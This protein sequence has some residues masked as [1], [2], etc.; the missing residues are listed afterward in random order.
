MAHFGRSP[1]K[2]ALP[3]HHIIRLLCP[4]PSS[5]SASSRPQTHTCQMASTTRCY[6]LTI[7]LLLFLSFLGLGAAAAVS[8]YISDGVFDSH[9]HGGSTG[10]NLLQ[11]KKSKPTSPTPFFYFSPFSNFTFVQKHQNF[12]MAP[13]VAY[14]PEFQEFIKGNWQDI[15]FIECW[16]H[17]MLDCAIADIATW[18]VTEAGFS[19]SVNFEFMNYTILTSQ[20][21]GPK[22][23]ADVCCAAFKD[24]ACP[25]ASELNDATT[26][27]AE[28][29]FSYINL[30]GKYPPGLFANECRE[31]KLGL[32]CLALSPDSQDPNADEGEVIRAFCPLTLLAAAFAVLLLAL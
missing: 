16:G 12:L 25:Y 11:A 28:T 26:D 23:S 9:G 8:A 6:P 14:I 3:S 4:H 29:M 30:Y 32:D 2:T 21:K 17:A 18:F 1:T 7:L 31:G 15:V 24:F 5:S 19:C 20:C 22:Y 13:V 27:C 10:R